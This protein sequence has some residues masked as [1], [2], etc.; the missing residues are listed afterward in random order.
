MYAVKTEGT[1]R[2]LTGEEKGITI[3]PLA[4]VAY[5]SRNHDAFLVNLAVYL[6]SL[7]AV[8]FTPPLLSMWQK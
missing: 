2:C 8:V 3:L 1:G 5:D 6:H 4:Q 7:S